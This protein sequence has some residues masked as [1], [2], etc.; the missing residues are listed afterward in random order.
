MRP[1]S[2]SSKSN[3][4]I[5]NVLFFLFCIVF[6][7]AMLYLGISSSYDE[8]ELDNKGA[9]VNAAVYDSRIGYDGVI[10]IYEVRYQFSIDGGSTWYS[11]SDRTGGS[12]LWYPVTEEQWQ[13]SQ[14]T[15]QVEITY[16]PGKPWINRPVNGT[17]QMGDA[18]AG[19]CLGILPWLGFLMVRVSNREQDNAA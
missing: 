12:R 19:V 8:L 3:R 10:K 7:P 4:Y 1:G 11:A 18:L 17:I 13:V 2:N 16:L 9:I 14:A 5:A 15:R 6:S